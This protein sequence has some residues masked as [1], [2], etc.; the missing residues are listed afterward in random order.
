M[1][2]LDLYKLAYIV[3]RQWEY[4]DF[5]LWKKDGCLLQ[6]MD[7]EPERSLHTLDEAYNRALDEGSSPESSDTIP[8]PP[9]PEIGL[10]SLIQDL[11]FHYDEGNDVPDDLMQEIADHIGYEGRINLKGRK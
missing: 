4:H 5:D 10:L 8:S 2:T 3:S 11:C 7:G 1:N 9:N 6:P